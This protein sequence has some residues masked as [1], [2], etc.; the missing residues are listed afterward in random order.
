MQHEGH[1]NPAALNARDTP[2]N[3]GV[4]S[5]K[6]ELRQTNV[7]LRAIV[8]A[9]PGLIYAKDRA[10]RLI[11]ANSAALALIGKPWAQVQGR[12]DRE[13]LDNP[14]EGAVVSDNDQRVMA[15]GQTEELEEQITRA[16]GQPRIFL[17]KKTPLRDSSGAVVGLVGVSMDITARKRDEAALLKLNTSLEA[18]VAERTAERDRAWRNAQDLLCVL[19]RD[20]RVQAANPAWH[21]V[22]GWAPDELIGT[23]VMALVHPEDMAASHAALARA[24][25]ENLPAYNNR[26]R[27]KDGSWRF[28]AWVAAPE[29]ELVYASGRNVTAE[30]QAAEA[31][32]RSEA[33]LRQAQK[34]EAIG[35]LTGGIAH[36]FNN[37]LQAISAGLEMAGRA[38]L[39]GQPEDAERYMDGT[40]QS[41]DRAAA[42]TNR[43]LAFSRRQALAPTAVDLDALVEGIAGLIR[44]IVG[45]AIDVQVR[46]QP[47]CWPV[48]CDPHQMENALLNLA[49]NGRDAMLPEGGS[50]LVETAHAVL[51]K[52]DLA[53]W[54]SVPA[55]EY[56]RV[57][58]SDSGRGMP[59]DVMAHAFEPFFTTKPAGQG[60]G[61]GLSQV[62]GFMRQ[63][64]GFVRLE[65]SVGGGTRV[66]LLLPRDR[67]ASEAAAPTDEAAPADDVP[68]ARAVVMLVEDE[69]NIRELI[70]E[71]LSDI[72]CQ[73]IEAGDG[74]G[75]LNML[76][77]MVGP[78][79]VP[80]DI[81]VADVGLP[82]GLN[83][84][85]LADA[86]RALLPGLPILLIT[87]YVG[88]ALGP[89][90]LMPAGMDLMTK[91]F[92]LAALT[93]RVQAML[94]GKRGAARGA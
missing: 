10:G 15:L 78:G 4:S 91:P 79:A 76:R 13:F 71:A 55:G 73:V 38:V 52:A 56:V 39:R 58:V 86:A 34:M 23:S 26:M 51:T 12:T 63:S 90:S 6:E 60:T 82:G 2:E 30:T 24:L 75:G 42:L 88:D 62:Y 27:H 83:G 14:A 49:I 50:L 46:L 31:L 5:I 40:R 70:A 68:A 16:A 25:R 3:A 87:G 80:P 74:P 59:P 35:Q 67:A 11:L 36:D 22:L 43:L 84:R 33:A 89:A 9:A 72:G 44:Q 19:D 8:E 77:G 48:R 66:H 61:L 28:F 53:G 1:Q 69:A 20:G 54:D 32:A 94:S 47:G 17:S 93:T 81:L 92:S 7:L 21:S 85:Q 18:L 37:M 64:E 57:T 41:V 29:G 65:S 45:P